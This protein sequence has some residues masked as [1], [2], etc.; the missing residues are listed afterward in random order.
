MADSP[1]L[2]ETPFVDANS[3]HL[4]WTFETEDRLFS[5]PVVN[6]GIVYVGS[7]RNVFAL[8]AANGGELWSAEVGRFGPPRSGLHSF[9]V[10]HDGVVY[11]GTKACKGVFAMDADDGSRIWSYWTGDSGASP[12]LVADGV[13]YA[14]NDRQAYALSASDGSKLWSV[15]SHRDRVTSLT[16]DSDLLCVVA[17]DTV[18]RD[19]TIEV[20]SSVDGS[21]V[22]SLT[23]GGWI[24]ANPVAQDGV[25]YVPT[26]V[27]PGPYTNE[28]DRGAIRAFSLSDGSEL[29]SFWTLAHVTSAPVIHSGI[30]YFA[31]ERAVHALNAVDGSQV[32]IFEPGGNIASFFDRG[33]RTS[34]V[35]HE[36]VVYVGSKKTFRAL[37]AVDGS[38]LWS[39][40]AGSLIHSVAVEDGVAYLVA[41]KI[42]ALSARPG[43]GNA[44]DHVGKQPVN[45]LHQ[46]A[47]V[48]RQ[49]AAETYKP[50]RVGLLL[51][52]E[53]P[54][55][56]LDRYFYFTDVFE[57]DALFRYVCKGIL[58]RVPDRS[59]K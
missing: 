16:L 28:L 40:E 44:G 11:V 41:D 46:G 4:K 18:P 9:P 14:R 54:P 15:Y 17:E 33:Y 6:D 7:D 29:W 47:R 5:A 21:K 27:A 24:Y 8:S 42:Y 32:W 48:R 20:L 52:A 53:G 25:L 49:Q 43:Q 45:D 37:A 1:I 26:T 19:G 55:S 36:D 59:E 31:S 51:V 10:F 56:S 3:D 23:N 39:F 57:Q 22:W 13:V 35:V 12:P 34:P 38:E 58:G 50:E 2:S 30:V